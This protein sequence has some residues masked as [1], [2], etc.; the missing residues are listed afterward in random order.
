MYVLG[1]LM[2]LYSFLIMFLAKGGIHEVFA[3]VSFGSGAI[4]LGLGGIM[5]RLDGVISEIGDQTANNRRFK[6]D[7]I[8]GNTLANSSPDELQER[9]LMVH[10]GRNLYKTP[11]GI[12]VGERIFANVP[13]AKAHIAATGSRFRLHQG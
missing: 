6:P 11:D 3:A 12:R 10:K 2:M 13:E 4:C 1:V 7:T 5:S 8:R 9:L